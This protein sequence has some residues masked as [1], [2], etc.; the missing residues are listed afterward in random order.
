MYA[1]ITAGFSDYRNSA[2]ENIVE[3]SP[4]YVTNSSNDIQDDIQDDV[5]IVAVNKDD[6]TFIWNSIG[7]FPKFAI[8]PTGAYADQQFTW[9][10]YFTDNL[11]SAIGI[12]KYVNGG[13][14]L[15][16]V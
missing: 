14:E 4:I 8:V 1:E 12:A 2:F 3:E 15:V 16:K 6:A 7:F 9:N 10:M 5:Y 13:R 11:E